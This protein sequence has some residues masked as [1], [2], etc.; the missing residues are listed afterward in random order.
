MTDR[1]S[2]E[3]IATTFGLDAADLARALRVPAA[4][5][6][7]WEQAGVPAERQRELDG[8]LCI[9]E[10]LERKLK[11]GLVPEAVRRPADAYDGRSILQLLADGQHAEVRET[12]AASFDWAAGV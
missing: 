8:L 6:E 9:A 7:E 3:Q 12:V 4:V 1:S 2:L 5:L 11:P 10:I